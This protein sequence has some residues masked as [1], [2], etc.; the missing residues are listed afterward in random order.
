MNLYI[1]TQWIAGTKTYTLLAIWLHFEH[2]EWNTWVEVECKWK[3]R[4]QYKRGDWAS[5]LVWLESEHAVIRES[6]LVQRFDE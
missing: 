2:G 1:G 5:I 6:T 4:K 3:K